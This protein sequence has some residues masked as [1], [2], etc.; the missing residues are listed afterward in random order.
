[1]DAHDGYLISMSE[2]N[3]GP[4]AAWKNMLDWISRYV[5]ANG[6]WK[7]TFG[8]NKLS[9]IKIIFQVSLH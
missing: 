5:P 9:K 1:M 7:N 6:G 2:N 8:G 4:T 3:F